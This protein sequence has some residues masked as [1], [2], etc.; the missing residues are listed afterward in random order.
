MSDKPF[1]SIETQIKI[2]R[3]R[4]VITDED[5]ADALMREGYY[6]IVNGYK[7]PFLERP[8]K[9]GKEERYR[10]GTRFSDIYALFCFDRDL[11]ALAF[12]F[13]MCVESLMRSTMSYSFSEVHKDTEA[14]LRSGCYTEASR[15][16]RGEGKHQGDLD[17][18]IN[19]LE[20]HARGVVA[21]EPEA[22][23]GSDVRVAHY[24]DVHGGVPLWVLFCELTFGNLKYFF[25]LMKPEEQKAV[26]RRVATLC[27]YP[28][29]EAPS[30][31]ELLDD[32]ELLVDGRNVC[33]HGERLYSHRFESGQDCLG[34]F[35]TLARYLSPEDRDEFARGLYDMV[36]R[37]SEKRPGI[38]RILSETSLAEL[39]GSL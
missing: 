32:L 15:Y 31:K 35:S 16:L 28:A 30:R 20:H 22:G 36:A 39:A 5:T 21:D 24:R 18:M 26:C 25:A 2:L 17:W 10:E 3:R 38:M 8:S 27:G 11:R 12:R 14:Y 1:A 13:L 9:G 19:T 37:W 7:E 29:E 23:D 4:G 34:F 6:A 33:A